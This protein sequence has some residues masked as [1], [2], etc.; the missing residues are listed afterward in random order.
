MLISASPTGSR[1][2]TWTSTA[3]RPGVRLAARKQPEP[4]DVIP[5][6][7]AVHKREGVSEDPVRDR[8][9]RIVVPVQRGHRRGLPG[10]ADRLRLLPLLGA[11]Q[12]GV[13][14]GGG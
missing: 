12:A 5:V 13:L 9:E 11:P 14:G 1:T 8:R 7:R 4:S 2:E 3:C 6:R 10:Q